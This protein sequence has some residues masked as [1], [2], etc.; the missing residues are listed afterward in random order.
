MTRVSDNGV[1]WSDWI[2]IAE[3]GAIQSETKKYIQVRIDL[4]AGFV[5]DEFIISKSD[6]NTNE[7][8][9]EKES[10]TSKYIAPTLTSNTS[11]PLGFAF[12]SSVLSAS[13]ATW[14]AFDKVDSNYFYTANEVIDGFLGFYFKERRRVTKLLCLNHGF[15][16]EVLTLQMVLMV[17]GII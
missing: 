5:T 11:S 15:Y 12:S 13:Y 8:I 3:D 14:M 2:V 1:N 16:K 17:I 9:E 7:Y 4:F 10:K 6:F